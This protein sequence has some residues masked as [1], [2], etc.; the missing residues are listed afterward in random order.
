MEDGARSPR[1]GGRTGLEGL[2]FFLRKSAL[3]GSS[4]GFCFRRRKLKK[5]ERVWMCWWR[6]RF[7][8]VR[9]GG[10]SWREYEEGGEDSEGIPG[11]INRVWARLGG[12]MDIEMNGFRSH[13][14]NDSR[15]NIIASMQHRPF[16]SQLAYI[17]L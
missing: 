3:R 5:M 17:S 4:G 2:G 16:R 8:T 1:G 7:R 12:M 11:L 15:L 13:D 6:W 14:Y 9:L 10:L